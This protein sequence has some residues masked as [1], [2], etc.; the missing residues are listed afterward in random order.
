MQAIKEIFDNECGGMKID[1]GLAKRLHAYQTG[2]V[3]KN[4]E[5][6]EFFGGHL[7]GVQAVKFMPGDRDRWFDEI[8][9]VDDGPL[10]DRLDELE[11]IDHNYRIIASETMNISCVWLAHQIFMSRL[12]DQQKHTAMVDVILVLQYKFLTSLLFH[13]FRYPADRATAEATYA[14]LSMKF[15]IKNYG[16]WSAMLVARAEEII[17][18]TGIHYDTIRKMNNDDD[19]QRMLNDIQ[20][21][22]R[23]MVKNIYGVFVRVH[24]AGTK[25]ISTSAVVEY[26]GVEMLRDKS[27]NLLAYVRYMESIVTDKNSFMKEELMVIIEKISH[28]MPPHLFRETL[29]YISNNYRVKGAGE[30]EQILSETLVHSY[31]YISHHR[32]L[33][34]KGHDLAELLKRLHGVYRASRGSDVVLYS[35]REKVEQITKNATGNKNASTLA[36]VRT[37]VLLYIVLRAFTMKHY[38][39]NGFSPV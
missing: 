19:V 20:G 25:F 12:P 6:I 34:R 30:V 13:Y 22:I 11:I 7:M 32:E 17:S 36:A 15:M 14:E 23:D 2:F 31:D 3:N 24:A 28:T 33:V 38:T 1:A 18:T 16:N 26:D 8:L 29:L 35:L 27:Q 4:T 10:T 21:R 9:E 5:H 37:G 39:T